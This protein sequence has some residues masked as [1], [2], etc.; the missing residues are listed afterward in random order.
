MK[1]KTVSV[2]V[3]DKMKIEE[4]NMERTENAHNNSLVP[5]IKVKENSVNSVQ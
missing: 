5:I 2:S 1:I 3:V 4:K